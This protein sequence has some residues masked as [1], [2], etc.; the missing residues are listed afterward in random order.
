MSSS[1]PRGAGH[2]RG[3]VGGNNNSFAAYANWL[4]RYRAFDAVKLLDGGRKRWELDGREVTQDVPS[5]PA[6]DVRISGQVRG[7]LCG[8]RDEVLAKLRRR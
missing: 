4:S 7:E 2:H 1:R 6:S 5:F 3:P 8:R